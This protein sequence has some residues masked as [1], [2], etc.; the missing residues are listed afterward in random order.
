MASETQATN[1][2]SEVSSRAEILFP[3]FSGGK[4]ISM[5]SITRHKLNGLNYIQWAR[6]LKVFIGNRGKEYYLSREV[7][8]LEKN[9]PKY[10]VWKIEKLMVISWLF[11]FVTTKKSKDFMFYETAR[12]IWVATRDTYSNN[13]NIYDLFKLQGLIHDLR[14]VDMPITQYYN[15]LT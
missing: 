4:N 12:E 6:S 11:N 2:S 1:T 10:K 15:I 8:A 9:N 13:E 3:N 14:Q 5:V 7:A